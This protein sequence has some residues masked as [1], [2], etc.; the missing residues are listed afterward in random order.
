VQSPLKAARRQVRTVEPS[1]NDAFPAGHRSQEWETQ[2]G[3]M[4]LPSQV[5]TP[6]DSSHELQWVISFFL[7]MIPHLGWPEARQ[8]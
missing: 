1:Q 5:I 3:T 8:P 4:R 6:P 7:Q 2:I